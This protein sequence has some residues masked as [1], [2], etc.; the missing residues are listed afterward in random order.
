MKDEKKN[1]EKKAAEKQVKPMRVP[2]YFV[3]VRTTGDCGRL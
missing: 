1:E 2:S 3:N